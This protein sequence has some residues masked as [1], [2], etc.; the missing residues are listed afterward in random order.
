MPDRFKVTKTE[1]PDID[2][3]YNSI[4]KD[5]E[6]VSVL[7]KLL[8]TPTIVPAEASRFKKGKLFN[9]FFYQLVL[10]QLKLRHS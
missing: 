4:L 5:E 1:A 3:T 2:T 7:G 10:F 6:S 8:P 9:F